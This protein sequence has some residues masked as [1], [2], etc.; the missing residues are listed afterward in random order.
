MTWLP[1]PTEGGNERAAV[2]GLHPEAY[3]LHQTFLGACDSMVDHD[4]LE[5][6]RARMAQVLRCRE[7]LA[8][9]DPELLDR[10]RS[11]YQEPSFTD[12]QRAAI[13]FVEQFIVD[14]SLVT[15]ELVA[16]LEA[17]LGTTG[18]INFTTAI[19]AYEA[20]IRLSALLDL[21]PTT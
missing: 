9:H 14:P 2:L 11:W 7:E 15:S 8:R 1:V 4:L 19:S 21:E 18:V 10:L 17:E 20:S 6:S 5:L 12:R 13:A 3:R 16:P